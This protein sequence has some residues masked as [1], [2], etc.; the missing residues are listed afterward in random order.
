MNISEEKTYLKLQS[1]SDSHPNLLK[2]A[3]AI[4]ECTNSYVNFKECLLIARVLNLRNQNIYLLVD[5][6]ENLKEASSLVR[7]F[8][9]LGEVHDICCR[10]LLRKQALKERF[11]S[12]GGE[13]YKG[14]RFNISV[15]KFNENPIFGLYAGVYKRDISIDSGHQ[16]I[17]ML[18]FCYVSI[19]FETLKLNEYAKVDGLFNFSNNIRKLAS[20]ASWKVISDLNVTFDNS[21]SFTE[22]LSEFISLLTSDHNSANKDQESLLKTC[23]S[24]LHELQDFLRMPSAPKKFITTPIK[25]TLIEAKKVYEESDNFD[26]NDQA[27]EKKEDSKFLDSLSLRKHETDSHFLINTWQTLTNFEISSIEEFINTS[28]NK[29]NFDD[30][31]L[32]NRQI[33]LGFNLYFGIPLKQVFKINIGTPGL[34]SINNFD[35]EL[36]LYLEPIGGI[37]YLPSAYLKIDEH[38]HPL[39]TEEYIPLPL[40]LRLI[41]LVKQLNFYEHNTLEEL[42]S[43]SLIEAQ[44][45]KHLP[46][47]KQYR[48]SSEK[49]TNT[50]WTHIFS[51]C[52][53]EVK[54][55]YLQGGA[56]DQQPMGIYYTQ[57]NIRELTELYIESFK[58]LFPNTSLKKI[59][60]SN[61]ACI[62]SP[63][64]PELERVKYFFEAKHHLL[65]ELQNKKFDIESF[66][67]FHNEYSLYVVS[68]LNVSS[69]HRVVSD[70]YFSEEIFIDNFCQITD[71]E[72]GPGYEGRLAVLGEV[73]LEQVKQYLKYRDWMFN[74]SSI[75]QNGILSKNPRNRIPF[76]FIIRDGICQSI[77]KKTII[78][79]TKS[80]SGISLV[81]NFH[82]HLFSS[83]ASKKNLPR[84]FI[85]AQMGHVSKGQ[86]IF[87]QTSTISPQELFCEVSPVINSLFSELK[88]KVSPAPF[89]KKQLPNLAHIDFF[90]R[91]VGPYERFSKRNLVL[92]NDDIKLLNLTLLGSVEV[93]RNSFIELKTQY[94]WISKINQIDQFSSVAF[95][96]LSKYLKHHRKYSK[97]RYDLR[98]NLEKS[99]FNKGFGTAFQKATKLQKEAEKFIKYCIENKV[100]I[101]ELRVAFTLSLIYNARQFSKKHIEKAMNV[102]THDVYDVLITKAFTVEPNKLARKTFFM[103]EVTLNLFSQAS[104]DGELFNSCQVSFEQVSETLKNSHIPINSNISRHIQSSIILSRLQMSGYL[105]HHSK[106]QVSNHSLSKESW[107]RL[108]CL[109]STFKHPKTVSS[110]KRLDNRQKASGEDDI[111]YSIKNVFKGFPVNKY[112][113]LL[114]RLKQINPSSN[115]APAELLLLEWVKHCAYDAQLAIS[116]IQTYFEKIHKSIIKVFKGVNIL[117][118]DEDDLIENFYPKIFND[119]RQHYRS[120]S[121][122]TSELSSFHKF[123]SSEY[124]FTEFKFFSVRSKPVIH[125]SNAEI[126][127]FADYQNA[128]NFIL[129]DKSL[130][131]FERQSLA[132]CLI[133]YY[134]LGLRASE[135]IKLRLIDYI[136]TDKLLH[137]VSNEH[138]KEKSRFGNR[139]ADLTVLSDSETEVFKSFLAKRNRSDFS[140]N[141]F[142]L[143]PQSAGVTLA[144]LTGKIR[145]YLTSIIQQSSR[146]NLLNLKSFRKSF[147]SYSILNIQ[148]SNTGSIIRNAVNLSEANKLT[149]DYVDNRFFLKQGASYNRLWAIGNILGHSSPSTTLKSYCHLT[150]L[151]LFDSVLNQHLSNKN[152]NMSLKALLG[153][154]M[155]DQKALYVLSNANKRHTTQV[156]PYI[157]NKYLTENNLTQYKPGEILADHD[158]FSISIDLVETFRK[159]FAL[160]YSIN[161]LSCLNSNEKIT[162]LLFIDEDLVEKYVNDFI[163]TSKNLL[164]GELK[165]DGALKIMAML[166]PLKRVGDGFKK[167]QTTEVSKQL[168]KLMLDHKNRNFFQKINDEWQQHF[169]GFNSGLIIKNEDVLKSF[170]NFIEEHDLT[171]HIELTIHYFEGAYTFIDYPKWIDNLNIKRKVHSQESNSDLSLIYYELRLIK[172][173]GQNKKSFKTEV[174][175]LHECMFYF[176]LK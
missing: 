85:S 141:S 116:S 117:D 120:E 39:S 52:H 11:P 62:G 137:I 35:N 18:H 111:V 19:L 31:E 148:L 138:G 82:R 174:T 72:L 146:N 164:S 143:F 44:K 156:F 63:H 65:N 124:G 28:T 76:F 95:H 173:R 129:K 79:Y 110:R 50:L 86:S 24:T 151:L 145:K 15:D 103:D 46:N 136:E 105:I 66:T 134:R 115:A 14:G 157:F 149:T 55:S 130:N 100:S 91:P 10:L 83:Y 161:S 36:S 1:F 167:I 128:L 98:N 94:K 27:T 126:I 159:V 57:L 48:F 41:E 75:E 109:E 43:I 90:T 2:H 127:C 40:P 30:E 125:L 49:I 123:L 140:G 172:A 131:R 5:A 170:F 29:Y 107:L 142:L 71:K 101:E 175:T 119:M 38:S 89:H 108:F 81:N 93:E 139:F 64:N 45:L 88:I 166:I 154:S 74:S 155:E 7:G 118:L 158:R 42:L 152:S 87:G 113:E 84:I 34:I 47:F 6:I 132:L 153:E 33:I 112:T 147:A 59:N 54:V 20:L 13:A 3:A 92:T 9:L 53:D 67:T 23:K 165:V 77:S 78:D 169:L 114:G 73:A 150:D 25:E 80:V 26:G 144:E 168:I 106:D 17:R 102:T 4:H 51:H 16:K 96:V 176:N 58:I 160:Y 97:W 171:N 69:T 68:L 21:L 122:Y 61:D 163:R 56:F 22:A 133:F 99:P 162:D 121:I 12:K 135:V 60:I 8:W 70:P 32:L 104:H 37:L